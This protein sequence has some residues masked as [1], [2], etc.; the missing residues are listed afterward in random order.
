V[1][2]GVLRGPRHTVASA[3]ARATLFFDMPDVELCRHY[4]NH[5]LRETLSC[6]SCGSTNR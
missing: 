1:T 4:G 6:K 3:G 5:V 2:S